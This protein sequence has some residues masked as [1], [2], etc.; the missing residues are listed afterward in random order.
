MFPVIP[1]CIRVG[2]RRG[3]ISNIGSVT[4]MHIFNSSLTNEFTAALSLISHPF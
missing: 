3:D 2:S 1:C 4:Y